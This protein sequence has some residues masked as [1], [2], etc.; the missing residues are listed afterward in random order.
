MNGERTTSDL[1]RGGVFDRRV[2]EYERGGERES[3]EHTRR[4]RAVEHAAVIDS[5]ESVINQRARTNMETLKGK[6]E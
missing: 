2:R 5:T 1:F 4:R 6:D 3:E